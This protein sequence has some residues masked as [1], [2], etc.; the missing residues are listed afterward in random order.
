L[1]GIT[2]RTRE[3][4]VPLVDCVDVVE[5][6]EDVEVDVL[7]AAMAGGRASIDR[8]SN[9]EAARVVTCNPP[10]RPFILSFLATFERI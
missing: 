5:V 3:T 4:G 1:G 8:S 7:G 9:E 6:V 2:E 10:G